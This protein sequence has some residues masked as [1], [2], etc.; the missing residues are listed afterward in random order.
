MREPRPREASGENRQEDGSHWNGSVQRQAI[1]GPRRKLI[2]SSVHRG[3][4]MAFPDPKG[5]VAPLMNAQALLSAAPI[6][7]RASVAKV[8]SE[9]SASYIG[10]RCRPTSSTSLLQHCARSGRRCIAPGRARMWRR[11]RRG[12][13]S[14]PS[15]ESAR[16]TTEPGSTAAVCL[17]YWRP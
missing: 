2:G 1:F 8:A 4:K 16:P 15:Q 11:A 3:H 14:S 10:G 5:W 13:R 17:C 9:M 6:A 7:P 12:E